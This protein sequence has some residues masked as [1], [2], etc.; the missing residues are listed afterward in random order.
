MTGADFRLLR[1]WQ[2]D[3]RA[4]PSTVGL[5]LSLAFNGVGTTTLVAARLKMD[6]YGIDHSAHY[7]RE[8]RRRIAEDSSET[9]RSTA[10]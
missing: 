6:Y 7:C 10:L 4:A 2:Q 8:A 5:R 1:T 3:K 9:Y